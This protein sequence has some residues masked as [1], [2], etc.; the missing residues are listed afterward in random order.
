M[1]KKKVLHK[2]IRR[3]DVVDENFVGPVS[4]FLNFNLMLDVVTTRT[5]SGYLEI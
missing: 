1:T 2:R 4:R 3:M 5:G